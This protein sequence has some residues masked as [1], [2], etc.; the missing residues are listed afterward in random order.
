V[1][2]FF[3]WGGGGFEQKTELRLVILGEVNYKLLLL[4]YDEDDDANAIS[5]EHKLYPMSHHLFTT[6]GKA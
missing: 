4:L 5:Y 6:L 3:F 2:F 1:I